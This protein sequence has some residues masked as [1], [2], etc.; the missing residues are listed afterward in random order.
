MTSSPYEKASKIVT[1]L[2]RQLDAANNPAEFLKKIS[3]FLERQN[4]KVLKEIATVMKRQA[5]D[6][7][8][9]NKV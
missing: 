3:E 7:S 1:V 4:D 2:Q 9:K 6:Q 8:K 5:T